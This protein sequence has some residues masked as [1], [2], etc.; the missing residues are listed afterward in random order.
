LSEIGCSI[1]SNN[2]A[3][4]FIRY[5][6]YSNLDNYVLVEHYGFEEEVIARGENTNDWA[7]VAYSPISKL[8]FV[9]DV[10]GQIYQYVLHTEEGH[11]EPGHLI[12]SVNLD[13]PIKDISFRKETLW[14][15]YENG[16]DMFVLSQ[17]SGTQSHVLMNSVEGSISLG[18]DPYG[19]YAY[20]QSSDGLFK[21]DPIEEE[22]D[23]VCGS[24]YESHGLYIDFVGVMF[25]GKDS[26]YNV[27]PYV[28]HLRNCGEETVDTLVG[29]NFDSYKFDGGELCKSGGGSQNVVLPSPSVTPT[30]TPS[31]I[32]VVPLVDPSPSSAASNSRSPTYYPEGGVEG[33]LPQENDNTI[34]ESPYSTLVVGTTG[35]GAVMFFAVFAV[36]M[37]ANNTKK[38][39]DTPA[40]ASLVEEE[41]NHAAMDNPTFQAP[42]GAM[43]NI[44][45]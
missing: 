42:D 20:V 26:S 17:V 19:Y 32:L 5:A 44:L 35:S 3:Y 29:V 9:A 10:T 45:N 15:I 6:I 21:Y 25:I 4:T 12:P 8:L 13:L 7:G 24:P 1:S 14:V 2:T 33:A 16:D 23:Q 41:M 37:S 18:W 43:E 34:V 40:I 27:I 22:I 11:L 39:P 38:K 36:V 28:L 30:R 31:P